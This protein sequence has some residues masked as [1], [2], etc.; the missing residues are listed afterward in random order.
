[1]RP[2]LLLVEDA[3]R[4]NTGCLHLLLA[5][6]TKR[7]MVRVRGA[8]KKFMF[9]MKPYVARISSLWNGIVEGETLLGRC[10]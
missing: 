7:D 10:C 1:M 6:S 4:V 8:I 5:L 9:H 3:H 2:R